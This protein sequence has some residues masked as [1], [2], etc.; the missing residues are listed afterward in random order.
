MRYF[1]KFLSFAALV[2]LLLSCSSD[3][4]GPGNIALTITGFEPSYSAV[5]L[6]WQLQRPSDLIVT[7]L[8]IYRLAQ[9]GDDEDMQVPVQIANLPSNETTY[10]DNDVPYYK[11]VTYKVVITYQDIDDDSGVTTREL[12]SDLRTFTRPLVSFPWIPL[13]VQKDPLNDDIFHILDKA[14]SGTLTRYSWSDK[15]IAATHHFTGAGWTL[16]NRFQFADGN[17]FVCDVNGGI[18]RL[19]KDNYAV[20]GNYNAV[21]NDKLNAF[22][23]EGDRIYYQDNNVWNYYEMSTGSSVSSGITTDAVYAEMLSEH[24]VLFLFTQ[25][26]R[27]LGYSPQT[28]TATECFPV[29]YPD[30]HSFSLP[31]YAVDPYIFTWNHSRQKCITSYNGRIFNINTFEQEANLNEITGKHYIQFAFDTAGNIYGSVQGE[32]IIHKFNSNYEL[33]ASIPTKLYPVFPMV[34]DSG[35]QALGAYHPI[36]Y[37]GFVYGYEFNFNVKGAIEVFE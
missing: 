6:Q 21:I 23:I 5:S 32:K 28:C 29:F 30:S 3:N 37:W 31:P 25:G 27:V 9:N 1:K 36:D 14:G 11:E 24:K 4:D 33:I 12:Q 35:L 34:T 16:N 26:M 13:D 22:S 19:N 10:T 20:N 18:T 8:R 2:L 17:V 7:S 15:S